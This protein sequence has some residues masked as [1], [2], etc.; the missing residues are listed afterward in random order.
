M[1]IPYHIVRAWNVVPAL[2]FSTERD[3]HSI[4]C[5][6]FHF[7][8]KGIS[9]LVKFTTQI[10][11]I[12]NTTPGKRNCS[13]IFAA[14]KS[15][16]LSPSRSPATCEPWAGGPAAALCFQITPWVVFRSPWPSASLI[17][18][19]NALFNMQQLSGYK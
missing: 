13:L 9:S 1:R 3:Q 17:E 6:C 18:F 4:L 7:Q 16:V 10:S 2:H 14:L 8:G 12:H 5:Y 19:Q 15:V 11:C